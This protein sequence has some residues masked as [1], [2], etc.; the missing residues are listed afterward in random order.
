MPNPHPQTDP[1]TRLVTW[2]SAEPL[3]RAMILT[4]SR[5]RPDGPVDGLSDYDVILAVTDAEGFV[6][7]DGWQSAYGEPMVRSGDQAEIYG[8][9]TYFR[10]VIYTDHV[11]FDY[12]LWP[13]ELLARISTESELHS[14]LDAGY[15]VLLDKDQQ[16]S[17]WKR[18]SFQA[19]IPAR[20]TREEYQALVEE[21]WW[22]TTYVAK[23][24]W[25]NEVI[26]AKWCLDQDIKMTAMLRMLEWRIEIDHNWSI[27]P[28][29]LGRGLERLLPADTAVELAK[30]YVG[31]ALDDNWAALF[32]TAKLFRRVAQSVGAALAYP[33]PQ[34]VDDRVSAYLEEIRQMPDRRAT[35]NRCIQLPGDQG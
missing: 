19:Y 16:T 21:F 13:A 25:R 31:P 35:P 22:D 6:R 32:R 10:S 15:Q 8:V 23:A 3:V 24:L 5:A 17:G 12:T 7:D 1:L 26:F 34:L 11:K 29:V 14:E 33:Y 20:P 18:P 4:S 30:T 28:G 2:G 27:R 9:T